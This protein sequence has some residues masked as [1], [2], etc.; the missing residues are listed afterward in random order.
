MI[1]KVCKMSE[2]KKKKIMVAIIYT[3]EVLLVV[4]FLLFYFISAEDTRQKLSEKY[5]NG[6]TMI[7]ENEEY[8]VGIALLTEL[9]DYKESFLYIEKA[10]NRLAYNRGVALFNHGDYEAAKELFEELKDADIAN[11]QEDEKT[12]GSYIDDIDLRLAE[13]E[14]RDAK[15]E[16]ALD[17]LNAR[18]Y[19]TAYSLL[20]ELDGYNEKIGGL[21]EECKTAIRRLAFSNTISAGVRFSSGVTED[22]KVEFAGT[23][24]GYKEKLSTWSDIVSI[25]AK[26]HFIIGLKN[27]GTVVT[28]GQIGNYRIDTSDWRDIIS[29]SAGELFIVGLKKDGTLTAQGHNGDGQTDIDE[30]SN[31]VTV[32]TGPRHTVGLDTSGTIHMTGFGSVEQLK[33]IEAHKDEWTDIVAISAGGRR[34]SYTAALK[35]DKSVVVAYPNNSHRFDVNDWDDIIAIAAGDSHLVGL[36]SNGQV[37]VATLDSGKSEIIDGWENIKAISAGYEFTLALTEN[38]NVEGIGNEWQG[39]INVGGW[40]DIMRKNEWNLIFDENKEYIFQVQK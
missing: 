39:Q 34:Y 9:G 35:K 4:L 5:K 18:D 23:D 3:I 31:I 28:T 7:D 15:Y 14:E 25:S 12:P 27:D 8:E 11:M 24:P 16:K 21:L 19:L 2:A 30:W 6:T 33:F 26:G 40:D 37:V 29:V 10:N 13:I 38:G 36:K 17:C 1:G 22:G 32:A 20:T